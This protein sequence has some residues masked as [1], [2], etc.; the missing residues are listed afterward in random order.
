MLV[1]ARRLNERI[2]IPCIRAAVRVV[3]IQHGQVRL[4]VEAPPEV[5]VFREEI[6]SGQL[7]AGEPDAPDAAARLARLQRLLGSRL[8]NVGLGLTLLC[9]QLRGQLPHAARSTLDKVCAEFDA[10]A[11]RVR[12]LM[13]PASDAMP[14]EPAA[15][16]QL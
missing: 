11:E 5:A 12:P 10:L 16:A 4:G 1:L 2:L 7:P 15:C 6:Y 9:R 3:S 8:N 13:E 14:V